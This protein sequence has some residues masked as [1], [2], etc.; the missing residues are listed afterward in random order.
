MNYKLLKDLPFAKA[1]TVCTINTENP[2]YWIDETG[3]LFQFLWPEKWGDPRTS[4]WF[5]PVK[6][7]SGWYE[8]ESDHPF[9]IAASGGIFEK[10]LA[11]QELQTGV[12]RRWK[13]LGL[14]YR[15][16]E[17]AEAADQWRIALT[18][19]RKWMADNNDGWEPDWDLDSV[20]CHISCSR[21]DGFDAAFSIKQLHLLHIDPLNLY[22]PSEEKAQACLDACR[23]EW[24]ILFNVK[25]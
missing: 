21:E 20:R 15:T 16:R 24:E 11:H 17:E 22:F 8:P 2:G 14:C 5:T 19:I 7:E 9:Y 10:T 4:G 3:E 1:G 6:E 13:S 25:S 23:S 18:T 12:A